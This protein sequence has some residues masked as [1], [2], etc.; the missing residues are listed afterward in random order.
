MAELAQ[1]NWVI[2]ID[3]DG[4]DL[5][6]HGQPGDTLIFPANTMAK[7]IAAGERGFIQELAAEL[8]GAVEQRRSHHE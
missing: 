8:A 2:A 1:L 4:S 6:L 7:R 5:A 3:A